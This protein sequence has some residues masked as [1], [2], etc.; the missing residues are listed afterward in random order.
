[1]NLKSVIMQTDAIINTGFSV[2]NSNQRPSYYLEKH[3]PNKDRQDF[4][5][6]VIVTPEGLAKDLNGNVMY[7]DHFNLMQAKRTL[8]AIRTTARV[9]KEFMR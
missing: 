6:W 2:M 5:K 4:F 1:M 7:F 8:K 9:N 3:Y